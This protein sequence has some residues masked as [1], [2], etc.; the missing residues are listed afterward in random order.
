MLLA[1]F[2]NTTAQTEAPSCGKWAG[3]TLNL[4]PTFKCTLC[5]NILNLMIN[6]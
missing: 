4:K 3:A 5:P 6:K 1:M 2:S